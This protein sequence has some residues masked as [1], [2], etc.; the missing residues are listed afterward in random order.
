[1]VKETHS[2]GGL[3]FISIALPWINLF[4]LP[5]YDSMYKFILLGII[6]YF[7][8][9]GSLLPD[10][11]MKS[12]YI[13]K[14]MPLIAKT[15]G[16]RCRHRGFTHSLLCTFLLFFILDII[17]RASDYN[18]VLLSASVGLLIGYISHLF[19]DLFTKEGIELFY[20]CKINFYLLKI[21]TNSKT[22]KRVC[23]V[24]S[25]LGVVGIFLD[26]L[27]IFNLY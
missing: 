16:K 15:F 23:K 18:I 21:K 5:Q 14:K 8:N 22:E 2:Y 26:F 11:D 7:A 4:L 24:L 12:S 19:L 6:L 10:I 9:L 1:M 20:P 27:L 3:F 17:L 25:T 13:S